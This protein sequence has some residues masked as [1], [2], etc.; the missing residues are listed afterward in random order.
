VAAAEGTAAE[1]VSTVV[2]EEEENST[3]VEAQEARAVLRG[4]GAGGTHP[5]PLTGRWDELVK[6]SQSQNL[7]HWGFL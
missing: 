7:G 3:T 4:G 5:M 2:E 6:S 1:A